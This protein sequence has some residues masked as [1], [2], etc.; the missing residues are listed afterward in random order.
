MGKRGP[1]PQPTSLRVL[2]GNPGNRPLPQNEPKP[3]PTAPKCPA[4]LDKE[5]KKEW[6]RVIKLLEP[7]G[8]ATVLDG[9]ALA[10]YC[11]AY[12][13]WKTA[14]LWIQKHGTTYMIRDNAGAAKYMQQVPHV[15]IANKAAALITKLCQE[16][17]MTPSARMQ[18]DL[19]KMPGTSGTDYE[20]F[21]RGR[22][23]A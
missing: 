9:T 8:L 6:R 4:W 3:E 20:R 22:E 2:R 10:M 23:N 13:R 21:R 7:L 14:E 18:L 1:R 17:G 15:A 5:A 16:F 19:P 12:S 11:T